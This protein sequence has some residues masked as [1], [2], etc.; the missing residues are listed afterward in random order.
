MKALLVC[1]ILLQFTSCIPISVAP[2]IETDK[3]MKG[4][5]FK[6]R[7]PKKHTFIF[8]DP[9]DANEFYNYINTKYQ[10]NHNDVE[11][12]VPFK[13]DEEQYYFS[14]HEVERKTQTINLLP[15]F[16]NAKLEQNGHDPIGE[17]LET[18]RE[19]YW[20]IA[21]TVTNDSFDDC[22]HPNYHK[23]QEIVGFLRS[24]RVEYL[25]THNYIEA[26]LKN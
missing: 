18:S 9:K 7:L 17:S 11:Y 12:N 16:W 21:I 19:N 14:F 22:L 26:M 6:K 1:I 24:L 8:E 15:I 5:K 25:T 2:S 10:L 20:Y 3:V 23:Q 4:K 13:V